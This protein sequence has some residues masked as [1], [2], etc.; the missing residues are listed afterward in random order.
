MAMLTMRARRFLQ[1]TG[2]NL[3]DNRPTSMGFAMSKV[4]CYNY[5]M[6]GHFARE[7]SFGV[8]AAMDLEEKHLVFNAAGEE[9]SAAKHKL[10]LLDTA[11]ER[12][13][14]LLRSYNW[15]YQAEEEP[16]NYALMAFSSSSFSSDNENDYESC[17]PSSLFDRSQPSGGY[18]VVPPLITGTFMPPKPDLVFYTA[19]I[20]I[21]TDHSTFTIQLST[22]KHAQDLSHTYRPSAPI[23]K[24]WVS[25]SEDEFETTA[26]Q[27]VPS[28]V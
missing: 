22:S 24:D 12:R 4:E 23:I 7:C 1:K 10:I 6:K 27:N 17:S 14:L 28:F 16:A 2:R 8:D 26:P 13:L 15:S 20:A 25:D 3:G 21:E 11:A 9:L 19:I 18:H 5:H